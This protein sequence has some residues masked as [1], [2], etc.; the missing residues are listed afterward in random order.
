M[1][2]E[3]QGL[4]G[5]KK[6]KKGGGEIK[7]KYINSTF[8]FDQVSLDSAGIWLRV[9]WLGKCCF[10]VSGIYLESHRHF[11]WRHVYANVLHYS[12]GYN[13][14]TN[15]L[16]WYHSVE[17]EKSYILVLSRENRKYRMWKVQDQKLVCKETK[18]L[19]YHLCKNLTED[20][21]FIDIYA[22]N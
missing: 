9:S 4:K 8:H 5:Q 21:N 17:T 18:I 12:Q 13:S 7:L 2:L 19:Y 3:L 22:K 6:K 11:L 1:K 15:L 20:S 16:L 10:G 14:L